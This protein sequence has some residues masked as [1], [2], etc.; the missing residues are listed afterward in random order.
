[1]QFQARKSSLWS[2]SSALLLPAAVLGIAALAGCEGSSNSSSNS[3]GLPSSQTNS[4]Q[5]QQ[6]RALVLNHG[7]TDCHN[8][9]V[10][11]PSSAK[12]LAGFIVGPPVGAPGSFQIGP[13]AT[14]AANLTPDAA[15]GIGGTSD[16]Q[17]Y[18]ALK[19]GLDPKATP[20][21]TITS[22]TP[23]QGNFPATPHY[24][25]PPMPWPSFRHETDDN[26]WAIVAYLK[27][28]L[29]PVTNPVPDSQAPPDF[30]ASSYTDAAVGP[31]NL[32]SFPTANEQV[33][34]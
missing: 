10:A 22:T 7:C 12:W 20:D 2:M 30:W 3:G 1:M 8:R 23:G 18:N 27:H 34:P 24:L 16:R 31:A 26:L 17:I 32:P 11:D 5:I 6:G 28:G 21:V 19:F 13:F 4:A 9:G 14:Y 29:K 33:A 15:T 25:A